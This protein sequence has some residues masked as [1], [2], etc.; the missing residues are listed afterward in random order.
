MKSL[1]LFVFALSLAIANAQQ[2]PQI[3]Q[4]TVSGTAEV[5]VAP[6]EIL[7]HAGVETRNENLDLARQQNDDH[8][9]SVLAF[10]KKSGVPSK[11]VQT[12][13]INVVPDYGN[14]WNRAP[15]KTPMFVVRKY[16]EVRLTNVTSFETVLTGILN[17]GAD[18]INNV[19]FRTTQLRKYR[20]QAR[21]MAI[22]AAKEK[23]DALCAELDVKRGAP[24]NIN[25]SESG[26]TWNYYSFQGY[27]LAANAVQNIAQDSDHPSDFSSDI[28]SLG[29]VSVSA[30][31]NVSFEL[32]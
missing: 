4:I 23:A 30:T 18:R 27:S 10:I 8:M 7:I 32:H 16:V 1:T 24:L 31:V 29:Q 19:E 26:G 2:S 28:L 14:E 17:A 15:S 3:P 9:K 13:F 21:A 11:D 5:R 25:A 20:D 22:K 6:D 12:D